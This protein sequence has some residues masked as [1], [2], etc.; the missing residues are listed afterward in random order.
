MSLEVPPSVD[1]GGGVGL[2]QVPLSDPGGTS[3]ANPVQQSAVVVQ[4]PL[5]GTQLTAKH[6][7]APLASGT[8]GRLGVLGMGGQQ[9]AVEAQAPPGWTQAASP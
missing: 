6:L 9:S 8:Q 4:A 5:S 2:T 1:V 3:Q 7:S